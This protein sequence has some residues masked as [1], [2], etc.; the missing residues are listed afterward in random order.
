MA[1]S[2]PPRPPTRTG[3]RF[4]QS[5]R[6]SPAKS[7][8]AGKAGRLKHPASGLLLW[9]AGHQ[10]YKWGYGIVRQNSTNVGCE[11]PAASGQRPAVAFLAGS[12]IR[13]QI[14]WNFLQQLSEDSE[15]V[16][17]RSKI[18]FATAWHRTWQLQDIK[19]DIDLFL[20]QLNE[21][22]PG[23][24]TRSFFEVVA[25]QLV[26]FAIISPY[27]WSLNSHFQGR[28]KLIVIL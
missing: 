22:M 16:L 2:R 20:M 21:H 26:R 14:M 27:I 7:D 18:P 1:P 8:L 3:L 28:K 19:P 10:P 24:L 25:P 5:G 12:Q 6:T 13:E 9:P 4:A 23:T 11:D 17:R 15:T